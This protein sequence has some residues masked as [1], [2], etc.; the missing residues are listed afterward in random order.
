ML[1][2]PTPERP[3]RARAIG[4]IG[5][6]VL[7]AVVLIWFWARPAPTVEPPPQAQSRA[8]EI[9]QKIREK[10]ALEP[11]QALLPPGEAAAGGPNNLRQR[12]PPK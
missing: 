10:E 2:P 6:L 3:S 12:P 9:A 4:G 8:E 11:P 7:C 5:A 1:P